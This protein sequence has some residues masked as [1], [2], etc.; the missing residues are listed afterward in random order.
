MFFMLPKKSPSCLESDGVTTLPSPSLQPHQNL[1]P[2][3]NFQKYSTFLP[4]FRHQISFFKINLKPHKS[5]PKRKL[6]KLFQSAPSPI[7]SSYNFKQTLP[8]QKLTPYDM[9]SSNKLSNP[10]FDFDSRVKYFFGFFGLLS[11]NIFRNRIF[12]GCVHMVYGVV[13]YD[14][15]EKNKC[16]HP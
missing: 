15:S 3:Q 10:I 16:C 4:L 14:R 6:P 9:I 7:R 12:Q 1:E 5:K 11:K 2:L 8:R 13:V